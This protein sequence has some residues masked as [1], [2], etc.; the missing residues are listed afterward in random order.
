MSP[1]N[2]A[3]DGPFLQGVIF[4]L[5][6]NNPGNPNAP[7]HTLEITSQTSVSS[8]FAFVEGNWQGDGPSAKRFTGSLTDGTVSL[9]CSWANGMSGTN[10]LVARVAPAS[11]IIANRWDLN[12]NV[13][14]T[15]GTGSIVSGAGPGMV[16]GEGQ[17]QVLAHL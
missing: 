17:A 15:N 9:T 4:H 10:T 2:T 16:S 1:A 11:Q 6:S 8:N 13:V 7:N 14:V 5:K 3:F 12:G